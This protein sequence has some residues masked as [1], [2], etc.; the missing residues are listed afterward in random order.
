MQETQVW[1]LGGEDPTE[2]GMV[3]HSSI[4]A[5]KDKRSQAGYR[6]WGRKESDTTEWLTQLTY[7]AVLV[8]TVQQSDSLIHVFAFFY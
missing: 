8:S 2:K 3:T 6:P 4:L 5:W 1:S 7:N